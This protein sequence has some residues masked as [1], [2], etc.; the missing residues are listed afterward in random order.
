MNFNDLIAKVNAKLAG[1]KTYLL[2]LG[3]SSASVG[4]FLVNALSGVHALYLMLAAAV[5]AT[6]RHAI[7][8]E[9]KKMADKLIASVEQSIKDAVEKAITPAPAPKAKKPK[10]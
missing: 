1:V 10:L 2:S 6:V 4:A 5:A 3:V 9:A 8:T 7:S